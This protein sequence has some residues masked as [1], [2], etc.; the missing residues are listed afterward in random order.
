MLMFLLFTAAHCILG[1]DNLYKF[2]TDN[3]TVT[4]GGHNISL[5]FEEGRISTGINDIQVHRD[6]DVKAET[7]DADIA[8][9]TLINNVTFNKYIQPIC[10]ID[11][12]SR[13]AYASSGYSVGYGKSEDESKEHENVLK[14]IQTPI[15]SSNEKCFY[16][17]DGLLKLSSLRTFCG[18]NRNGSGV[19]MGDSGNGLFVENNGIHYIRGIVS[20]SLLSRLKCD[21]NNFAIYTD[22]VKFANWIKEKIYYDVDE[23]LHR[24]VLQKKL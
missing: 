8:I 22:V 13:A 14:F 6:W 5:P 2:T 9:L 12:D 10:M 24:F 19:C 16:T 23:D 18:G 3:I 15:H 11:P 7:Y 1:K 4:L 17:N 21:V 20:S